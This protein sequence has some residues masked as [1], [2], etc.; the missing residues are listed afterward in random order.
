MLSVLPSR[1]P[2]GREGS[3]PPGVLTMRSGCAHIGR[4]EG[5]AAAICAGGSSVVD[6]LRGRVVIMWAAAPLLSINMLPLHHST[7][8]PS[9]QVVYVGGAL[10][11]S[12]DGQEHSV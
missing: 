8:V 2:S 7:F 1:S 10:P 11:R 6:R 3:F 9:R 4:A 5:N 12:L